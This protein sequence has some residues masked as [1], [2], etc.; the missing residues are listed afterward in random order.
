MNHAQRFPFERSIIQ[1]D[2][3]TVV[4]IAVLTFNQAQNFYVRE[5]CD[6]RERKLFESPFRYS[7]INSYLVRRAR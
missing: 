5:F 6:R 7:D 1:M 2:D 3:L 4:E